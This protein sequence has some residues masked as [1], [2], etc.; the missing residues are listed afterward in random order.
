MI[1]TI[2]LIT[3]LSNGR[4]YV[5][6]T[7]N[8]K[9]RKRCHFFP[10]KHSRS[11]INN[12]I[13]KYGD[14]SFDFTELACCRSL[15]DAHNVEML[16][17]SEYGTRV[18]NGYNISVGGEGG[19]GTAWTE[20]R[21]RALS[22]KTK[23]KPKS[24]QMRMRVSAALKGKKKSD[25]HRRNCSISQ[26]A[27]KIK[28]TPQMLA[29]LAKGQAVP[30]TDER[31]AKMSAARKGKPQPWSVA[32]A[33]RLSGYQTKDQ[34]SERAKRIFTGK[35]QTPEQVAKRVE[36]RRATIEQRM[37]GEEYASRMKALRRNGGFARNK[38]RPGSR[39]A[40]VS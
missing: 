37:K 4:Q 13:R 29:N 20:E 40:S 25:E 33:K 30:M 10:L 31:R 17:I 14:D 27:R 24:E 15:G 38:Y 32:Q 16:L 18:P 19:H 21:K 12:A 26:K 9:E 22:I 5:G 1:W 36:S 2:Y 39:N 28:V 34:L 35:K 11:V 3:N 7:R 8:L 6:L 23:G